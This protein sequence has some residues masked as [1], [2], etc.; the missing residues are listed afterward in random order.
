MLVTPPHLRVARASPNLQGLLSFYRDGL[1]FELLGTFED[2]AGFDGI[3]LGH[4][5]WPY[6]LEFTH[7]AAHQA[8][9][10]APSQESLLVCYL[11]ERAEW[12]S[13]VDRMR[14]SG[15]EPVPSLNP[16]W[17][18]RGLTFADPDGWRVVLQHAASEL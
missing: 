8:A 5:G 17:D 9:E 18:L 10:P 7:S 16:Y 11:P 14:A 1:G 13:A 3:M 2:H 6:H 4:A 15:F 12:Q